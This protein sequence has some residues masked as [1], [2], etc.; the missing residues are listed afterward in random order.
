MLG[1]IIEVTYNTPIREQ[2]VVHC[3]ISINTNCCYMTTKKVSESC[4]LQNVWDYVSSTKANVHVYT[5][6]IWHYLKPPFFLLA[7]TVISSNVL[8]CCVSYSLISFWNM[9]VNSFLSFKTL[10][11]NRLQLY[12]INLMTLFK[13]KTKQLWPSLFFLEGNSWQDFQYN[14]HFK[15]NGSYVPSFHVII[16]FE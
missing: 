6:I 16:Y 4:G 3:K 11:F 9:L 10:V 13:G 12:Y 2:C 15:C 7:F 1:G 14:L 5:G 8:G